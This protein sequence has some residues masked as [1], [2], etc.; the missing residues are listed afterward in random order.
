MKN[1]RQSLGKMGEDIASDYL[2]QKGYTILQ[3][4]WRS[5]KAEIDI[6]ALDKEDLVMVEVKSVHTLRCGHGEERISRRKRTMLILAA[7]GFLELFPAMSKKNLRFDVII[8]NFTS[9]P[10]NIAHYQSA[11]WQQT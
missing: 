3:R 7:Y 5:G 9:Y 4:N 10:A 2:Q 6:I 8:I 11:F 1:S